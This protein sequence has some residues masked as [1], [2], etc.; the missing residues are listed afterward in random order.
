MVYSPKWPIISASAFSSFTAA[1]AKDTQHSNTNAT[2]PIFF[3]H[4]I[5]LAS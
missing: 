4:S 2:I 5:T 3:Q 1:E